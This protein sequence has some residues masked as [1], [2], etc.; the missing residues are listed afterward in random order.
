ISRRLSGVSGTD[1]CEPTQASNVAVLVG[2]HV[3]GCE[4]A[5]LQ[6]TNDHVMANKQKDGTYSVVP[7]MPGG[8]V[9]PAGLIAIGHI[10]EDYGLYTKLT[11]GQRIDMFGA[12]LE[13]LPQIWGRLVDAGFESGQAYGKALRTV[14]SCVGS[15]WCRYGVLDAVGM[16]VRLELRYR[17]LRAPHKLKVGVSG[18]ARECAEA[19]SK[20]VGVIATETGW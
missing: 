3:H 13:Q 1:N 18:C 8:E 11:G 10:A 14:K 2:E 4:S 19:R 7:R 17:G 12:R 16:A 15:T 20:D 9:T 5:A 6:D